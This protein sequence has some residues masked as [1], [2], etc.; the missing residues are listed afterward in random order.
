MRGPDDR[1]RSKRHLRLCRRFAVPDKI[2]GLTLILDFIDRCTKM[3]VLH[4]PP[5]ADKHF[6][7]SKYLA[8]LA[9]CRK[10]TISCRRKKKSISEEMLF[11]LV[12]TTGFEPAASC[13]QSKRSTKLSHVRI[14]IEL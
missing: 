11:F 7:Q 8:L 6:A 14:N 4:L 3:L 10:G 12:R 2:F 5:A 13:S 9:R 1:V